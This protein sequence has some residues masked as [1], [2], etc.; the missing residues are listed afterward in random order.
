MPARSK[1]ETLP[2]EVR[3][4]LD[5]ALAENGFAKYELLSAQLKTKGYAL[6]KSALHRHGE[7]LERRLAAVKASTEAS[8]AM[9]EAMP[10][11]AGDLNSAVMGMVQSDIFTALVDLQ[12]AEDV[13]PATR[14]ALMAKVGRTLA[15][16]VGASIRLKKFSEDVRTRA[17]AAADK[18]AKMAQKGGLSKVTAESIR[19]EILGIA[20]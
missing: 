12:E 19:R 3:A 18:V 7:K 11:D 20:A 1:V 2:R 13:P 14:L 4:W 5:K 17:Q 6:S 15:P 9:A 16:M 10:D 8:R